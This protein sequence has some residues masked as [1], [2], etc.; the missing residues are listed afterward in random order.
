MKV[1][2]VASIKGGVGKTTTIAMLGHFA[3]EH[4]LRTLLIDA[5]V[6]AS[7]TASFF[8]DIDDLEGRHTTYNLMVDNGLI[9]PIVV[10]AN[11]SILPAD[12]YLYRLSESKDLKVMMC[13]KERIGE[14]FPRCCINR[15]DARRLVS[16][17]PRCQH[18]E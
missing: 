4:G 5:D 8:E 11:L 17:G 3:S 15:G 16:D 18:E 6:H 1:I 12:A 7:L 2:S 14:L 10:K 13:L 9:E